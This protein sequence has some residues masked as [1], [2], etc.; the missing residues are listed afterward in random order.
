LEPGEY[1]NEL[2]IGAERHIVVLSESL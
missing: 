1:L 2:L